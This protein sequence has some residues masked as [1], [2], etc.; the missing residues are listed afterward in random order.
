[1]MLRTVL[2]TAA[3]AHPAL[4][5]SWGVVETPAAF[6]V[7]DGQASVF[8][9]GVMPALGYYIANDRGALG[10][11]ARAGV[12]RDGPAPGMNFADPKTGGLVS[13]GVAFRLGVHSGWIEGVAG[14][15]ITGSDTVPVFEAGTGWDFHAGSVDIGPSARFVHVVAPSSDRLG[16]ADL[17]LV[18]VG[19]RF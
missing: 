16:S 1:M 5:D 3:L 9:P 19:L 10:I 14:A 11:R 15:G 2:V 4:A 13:G 12:L 18:G 8:R 17:V 6:A 7:S